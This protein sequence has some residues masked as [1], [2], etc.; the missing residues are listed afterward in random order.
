MT[1]FPRSIP[2]FT[3]DNFREVFWKC[4]S[5][6]AQKYPYRKQIMQFCEKQIRK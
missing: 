5:W 2:A 3:K 4:G 1:E 6:D